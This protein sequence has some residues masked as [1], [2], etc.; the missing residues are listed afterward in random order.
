MKDIIF[1]ESREKY[2][3]SIKINQRLEDLKKKKV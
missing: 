2:K 3:R 1:S